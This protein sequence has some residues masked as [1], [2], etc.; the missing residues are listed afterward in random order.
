MGFLRWIWARTVGLRRRPIDNRPRDAIPPHTTTT[1]RRDHW[2]AFREV[3]Q[4]LCGRR[5]RREHA[6]FLM[7]LVE[8]RNYLFNSLASALAHLSWMTSIGESIEFSA[9]WRTSSLASM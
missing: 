9:P 1:G 7:K 2:T 8:H 3:T 5:S 4:C 6:A